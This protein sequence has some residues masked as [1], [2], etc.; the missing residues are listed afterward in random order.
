MN[1]VKHDQLEKQAL[2][3]G[4]VRSLVCRQYGSITGVGLGDVWLKQGVEFNVLPNA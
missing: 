1:S 4:Q 2:L 3:L